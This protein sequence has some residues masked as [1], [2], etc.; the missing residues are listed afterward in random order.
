VLKT[1]ATQVLKWV[2][3]ICIGELR[4]MSDRRPESLSWVTERH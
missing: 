4:G 2:M 3:L 1:D